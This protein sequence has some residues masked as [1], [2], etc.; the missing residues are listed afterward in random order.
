MLNINPGQNNELVEQCQKLKEYMLYVEK[1]R[2]YV[3]KMP[4]AEAVERTVTECIKENIL[5][6]FLNKNRKEAVAVSIFEYNEEKAMQRIRETEYSKGIKAGIKAL[7]ETMQEL[8]LT[9]EE[10]SPKLQTKFSLTPEASA[11]FL[12]KYWK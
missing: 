2:M 5:R 10:I 9:K 7:I 8:G 4:I 12:K 6:E 1:M 11:E 3:R